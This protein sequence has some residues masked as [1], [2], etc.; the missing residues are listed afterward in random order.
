MHCEYHGKRC[1]L[2]VSIDVDLSGLP[3]T[4]FSPAGS[5]LGIEGETMEVFM[6]HARWAIVSGIKILLIENV[7]QLPLELIE[8]LYGADFNIYSFILDP[9]DAGFE[10]LS[11]KRQFIL[12]VSR[13]QAEL[14]VDVHTIMDAVFESVK[15][16]R[17]QLLPLMMP[18][19]CFCATPDE[20][21]EEEVHL[22]QKR[23]IK[24]KKNIGFDKSYL[25]NKNERIR[26]KLYL[27][28]WRRKFGVAAKDDPNCLVHLGDNPA[29]RLVWSAGGK[30]PS[31][32]KSMGMLSPYYA[33]FISVS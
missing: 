19:A 4:D 22:A 9:S 5:R 26:L 23:K 1:K 2:P 15:A 10:M 32:R 24:V 16:A 7:P 27:K 33:I 17:R 3:C 13:A 18:S 11:R 21:R 30:V 12:L 14:T 6:A 28:M 20:V 25:I 31:L 8:D 29:E